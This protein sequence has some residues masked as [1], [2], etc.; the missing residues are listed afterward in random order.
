MFSNVTIASMFICGII[1]IIIPIAAM[2]IYK[3][4]NKEVKISSFFIGAATFFLFALVLEQI[5]HYFM[6]PVV[7]VSTVTYV[8]Y[9]VLAAGIFEETGR[10][11]AFKTVMKKRNDPKDAVMFGLGHGGIEAIILAGITMISYGATAV[12][13]NMMGLDAMVSMSSG[14]NA[15]T[16]ELV[17]AQFEAMAAVGLGTIFINIPERII[18]M[19]FHTA[20]SVMVFESARVKG[21]GFMYPVCILF[22]AVL[23]VAPAL[24]QRQA[25]PMPAV[26]ILMTIFTA[27]AV[28]CAVRSY[29][30]IREA[31]GEETTA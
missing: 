30:R 25:I 26:Y 19:T 21:R 10:F 6:L 24:Y 27:A 1:C 12:M 8:I 2:I 4:K 28:F 14:E 22:H 31:S 16:A 20:M 15:E 3:K 18:A 7:S 5:M 11:I 13:T 17:R 29:R 9:G 23:D